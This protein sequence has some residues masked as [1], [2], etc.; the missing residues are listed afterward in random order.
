[1][2]NTTAKKGAN[3]SL[4]F[5]KKNAHEASASARTTIGKIRTVPCCAGL[6]TTEKRQLVPAI[7]GQKKQGK[8]AERKEEKIMTSQV[9][10]P[11]S[12]KV[13]RF[14]AGGDMS[15]LINQRLSSGMKDKYFRGCAC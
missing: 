15:L 3:L 1:M 12:K 2:R 5:I 7:A 9:N 8:D 13:I 6:E 4:I 10:H 14:H 11:H